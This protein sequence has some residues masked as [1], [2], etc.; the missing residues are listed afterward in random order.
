MIFGNLSDV[1]SGDQTITEVVKEN[2]DQSYKNI[3]KPGQISKILR[4]L[5]HYGMNYS[6]KVY[7]NMIAIPADKALQ[8]K[9]PL[10]QQSL[11][12]Q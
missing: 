6:D 4:T 9:D 3:Q 11:Y 12:G 8:P 5:S 10:I 1:I 7:K 2:F